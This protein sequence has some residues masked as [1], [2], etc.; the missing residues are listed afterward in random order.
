MKRSIGIIAVMGLIGLGSIYVAKAAGDTLQLDT[1]KFEKYPNM[2]RDVSWIPAGSSFQKDFD[3]TKV[4]GKALAHSPQS[5][6]INLGSPSI[7]VLP[8]GTYVA[9]HDLF[10]RNWK[11]KK[12][13]TSLV[14]HS[15][16]K[17]VTW[18]CV[19]RVNNQNW[20][21]LFWHNEALYLVGSGYPKCGFSVRKSIDKGVTWTE[22]KDEKSG[23]IVKHNISSS[24]M[25]VLVTG[26]RVFTTHE[27]TGAKPKP[28]GWAHQTSFILSAPADSDLL[29]ASN[30]TKS[31]EVI[32]PNEMAVSAHVG[33]L[34]GNPVQCKSS[35]KIFNILRTHGVTDEIAAFYEISSDGKKV[36]LDTYDMF[37]RMPG[38]CKK[39]YIVYDEKSG[40]HYALS[41]WTMERDR[42][43]VTNCP[44]KIK[45]ERTRNTLALSR[46]KNLMD[47]E[48]FSIIL[49][50]EDIDHSGFQYPTAVIEGDDLLILSR[51]AF[52][53]GKEKAEHQHNSNFIT[54]HR[55]KNF[56]ERTLK[57]TPLTGN[58]ED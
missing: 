35:G 36:T 15:I 21:S 5:Q 3:F 39:F 18:R 55:V 10:G 49:H 48:M 1:E 25:P 23:L 19:A 51:T 52:F 27:G 6:G 4:P 17:G 42:G 26:G 12:G 46:S 44:H 57:S 7:V 33:W 8:D 37:I 43:R 24:P 11:E 30:W 38:A 32:I 54:F 14:Y 34:E 45:A 29:D 9:S 56:R 13:T 22:A 50:D 58:I 16:D 40:M 31:N 53:D 47:W 2:A 41:N 20:S 28:R